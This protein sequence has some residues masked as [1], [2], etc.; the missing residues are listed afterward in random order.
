MMDDRPLEPGA[1]GTASSKLSGIVLLAL[2][3]VLWALG[4]VMVLGAHL[5]ILLYW[6]ELRETPWLWE[7]P[8]T[9][10]CM[11][12]GAGVV[13]F[14][15]QAR[16]IGRRH[17]AR[18]AQFPGKD[19]LF[20]LY[21]RS[22]REDIGRSGLE[23]DWLRPDCLKPAYFPGS[24][25]LSGLSIEEHLIACFRDLG[26][27]VSVR[28][29]DERLPPAGAQRL[30]TSQTEWQRSVQDLMSRAR[31]VIIFIDATPGTLWE[32]IEATRVVHPQRLLLVAPPTSERYEDF[33]T[34]ATGLLRD[35]AEEIRRQ[36]GECWFPPTLPDYSPPGWS[37]V[38]G[39]KVAASGLIY[40]S[41][42][43]TPAFSPLDSFPIYDVLRFTVRRAAR[44]ALKQLLTFEEALSKDLR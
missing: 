6:H 13:H 14:G 38:P 23:R 27:V 20:V 1:L 9:F 18:I 4:V 3:W 40:Y 5:Y 22:F 33:R 43:W 32:F 41:S 34:L 8:A 7:V 24:L 28:S 35:R 36:T 10:L 15:Q 19:E 2:G 39:K 44:P 26:R 25:F 42:D 21:L 30:N 12:A 37:I 29:D 31:L 16:L 11:G 17:L